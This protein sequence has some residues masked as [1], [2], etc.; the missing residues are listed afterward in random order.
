MV[1][2]IAFEGMPGSGKT[3]M[4]NKLFKKDL[5]KNSIVFSELYIGRID[6]LSGSKS[7]LDSE[8]DRFSK[9][10]DFKKK[11][12]T[13]I[14]DRT[15][16]STLAYSYARSKTNR[17]MDEYRD[18]FRY[19][20][21]IDKKHK[22]LRP[23]HLIYLDVTVSESIRR[24]KKFSKIEEYNNWFDPEFLKHMS[25]FYRFNINKLNMPIHAYIDTTNLS[26]MIVIDKI[27]A[28]LRG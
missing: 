5:F 16:L 1:E 10:C 24:R 4:I 13:I 8:I 23:T 27:V 17:N 2:I 22:L 18:V 12:D 20:K 19:F 26:E 25:E 21:N 28:A 6:N 7:Y 14:L 3:T 15:F 9:I 11:Y